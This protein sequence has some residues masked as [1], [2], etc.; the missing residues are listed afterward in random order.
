ME[1]IKNGRPH[2]DNFRGRWKQTGPRTAIRC[3]GREGDAVQGHWLSVCQTLPRLARH[4]HFAGNWQWPQEI[5][6]TRTDAPGFAPM[7]LTQFSVSPNSPVIHWPQFLPRKPWTRFLSHTARKI[8]SHCQIG[9]DLLFK[10]ELLYLSIYI[11]GFPN[12]IVLESRLA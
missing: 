3:L 7:T 4:C 12:L 6:Q 11:I 10:Y 2:W 5:R 1:A 9:Q 8:F